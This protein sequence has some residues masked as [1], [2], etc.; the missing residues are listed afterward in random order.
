ML[1]FISKFYRPAPEIERLP[2]DEIPR[3]YGRMRWQIM[4]STFI[5]YAVF[6]LVRNNLAPVSIEIGEA[7]GYTKSQIG[8]FLAVTAIAYGV[9]KFI[10]GSVSDRSNPR[11]F[12]PTGLILTALVNFAFGS[13]QNYHLHLA[14]W[15]MNGLFQGMGW[16]PCGRSIGHWYSE[17]ER[18]MKFAIWNV[19]TN[20]GGG[21]AGVIAAYS[22]GWLGWRFAFF[23]PG[24]LALICALY[25]LLRLRDT[26]QSVGLPPIEE[27]RNDYPKNHSL[28]HEAEL[29]T[30]DL[31]V[32]YIFKNK[33]LWIVALA[34]FFV[35]ITRYS[36]LDWGP[37][38]LREIKGANLE[39]GGVEHFGPGMG[40]HSKHAFDGL[41]IRSIGRPPGAR[42]PDVHDPRI[43]CFSGNK[44][45]P[46]GHALAGYD[47]VGGDRVFRLSAG[48]AAGGFRT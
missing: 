19:A 30:Q 46:S 12:M 44:N 20:V 2:S 3:T 36:M 37:T 45:E 13:L 4:E 42:Q 38:Y 31:F 39:D 11:L 9:A 7:V 6:Y 35:Y 16:A 23:V 32:N 8:D 34:N 27:Y 25:L 48:H 21:L 10:M 26:P 22:A 28:D 17:N 15:A 18:G 14:L 24:I 41:G 1:S 29:T 40:G 33:Y 47:T 5:G 43:F